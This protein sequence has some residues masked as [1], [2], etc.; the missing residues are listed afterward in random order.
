MTTIITSG[1]D[2]VDKS[3]A[4]AVNAT[5][6]VLAAANP[7]RK[8]FWIQNVSDD[9]LWINDLGTASDAH[10]S[11]LIASGNLYEFP[12]VPGTAISIYGATAGQ[13]FS[14]REW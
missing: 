11:I 12:V 13:E 6:Q 3:G 5:A 8:G 1:V 2:W 14:A 10:P 7:D 9:D 4:I